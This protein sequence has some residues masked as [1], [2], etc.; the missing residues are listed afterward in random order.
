MVITFLASPGWLNAGNGFQYR[1]TSGKQNWQESRIECQ[2]QGGDLAHVGIRD[3]SYR[4]YKT[5][6]KVFL[7]LRNQL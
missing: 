1:R 5:K 3:L 2:L 6:A 7:M 4:R